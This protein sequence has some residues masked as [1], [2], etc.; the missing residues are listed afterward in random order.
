MELLYLE[1]VDAFCI[2]SSDCDFT[3]L[4]GRIQE[5]GPMVY[6]FGEQNTILSRAC[7]ICSYAIRNRHGY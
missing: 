2:V 6:G 3:G 4:A 5:R 1:K 7:S